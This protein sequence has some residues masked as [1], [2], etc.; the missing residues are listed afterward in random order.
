MP[1]SRKAAHGRRCPYCC[2]QMDLNHPRLTPTRDHVVPRSYGGRKIVICCLTCNGIKANMLPEQ[3]ESY[4]AANPGW[5][6]LTKAERRLRT[7]QARNSSGHM[8]RH[9]PERQGSPKPAPVVVPPEL[10]WPTP[11][12]FSQMVAEESKRRH[13]NW[14][15]MRR[16]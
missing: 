8:I 12:Q 1:P 3:W 11:D 16:G 7:R 14:P 10:I 6:L 2:R 13:P 5:W 15:D 9:Q 4:M